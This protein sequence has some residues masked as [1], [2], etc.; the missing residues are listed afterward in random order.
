MR[1][2]AA[3]SAMKGR[4]NADA[5]P[6]GEHAGFEL[7]EPVVEAGEQL[8]LRAFEQLV[9]STGR[10]GD[11]DDPRHARVEAV[12]RGVGLDVESV[13]RQV[14][15]LAAPCPDPVRGPS[16]KRRD[17]RVRWSAPRRGAD[18]SAQAGEREVEELAET[19]GARRA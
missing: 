6:R 17:A 7:G 12:D 14:V 1:H 11:G 10:Q 18:R 8:V 2:R 4:S 13:D 3:R 9:G 16:S 5:V 19:L 15:A